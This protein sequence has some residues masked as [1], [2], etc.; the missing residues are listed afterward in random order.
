VASLLLAAGCGGSGGDEEPQARANFPSTF[1]TG[2]PV[3]T[4]GHAEKAAPRWEELRTFTGT[5]ALDTATFDVAPGAIQWRAKW[6]CRAGALRISTNPPPAKPGPL[7]DSSCP[8]KGQ[9]FSIQTGQLRLG[10]Q[11][12]GPWSV[13]VEQQV[14]TPINEPPLPGMVG[15]PVLAKGPFQNIEKQGKGTVTL[16]QLPNGER[17]LRFSEDF[18]VFNDPDLAVWVSEVANPHSSAEIVEAPHVQLAR[19]KA[20]R[21]PQNYLIPPDL[22][23]SKIRSVALY[24]IPVPSIYIAA[25]LTP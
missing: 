19:L 5:G 21:G 3:L 6:E 13:T 7:V 2:P 15:A 17:A 12:S 23:T 20:T 25:P 10:V 16:Y 1:V 8:G 22:P 14:D 24:C 4:E 9:G 18:Q 11:A